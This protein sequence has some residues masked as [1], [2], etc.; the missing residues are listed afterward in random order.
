MKQEKEKKKSE[1]RENSIFKSFQKF[2][3]VIKEKLS[4]RLSNDKTD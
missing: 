1:K 4:S 3:E 2:G